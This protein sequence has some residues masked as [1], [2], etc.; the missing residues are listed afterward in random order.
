MAIFERSVSCHHKTMKSHTPEYVEGP[1]AFQRFR[2]AM[3]TMKT[4]LEVSHEE[5][6]RRIAN[7]KQRAALN[8][9]KRG[10]KP[11]GKFVSPDPRA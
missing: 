1:E 10:P 4:V 3:K 8:P 9:R 5:I 11:K 6:Q 2:G 7:E